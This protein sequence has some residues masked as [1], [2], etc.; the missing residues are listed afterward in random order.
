MES[1]SFLSVTSGADWRASRQPHDPDWLHQAADRLLY[2]TRAVALASSTERLMQAATEASVGIGGAESAGIYLLDDDRRSFTVGWEAT[3]PEWP[4]VQPAGVRLALGQWYGMVRAMEQG[5]AVPWVHGDS[6]LSQFEQEHYEREGVGSG[7]DVPLVRGGETVGFLKL[8]RRAR[9]T[10]SERD[11]TIAT[12]IAATIALAVVGERLLD[13]AR[14]QSHDQE[15]LARIAQVAIA[16]REPLDLL[17]RVADEIRVLLPFP[18]VD[19]ELWS[20]DLD[21]CEL[22]AHSAEPGWPAPTDGLVVYRLSERPANLRVLRELR[23]VTIDTRDELAAVERAYLTRRDLA[24]LHFVPLVYAEQC[25]GAIVIHARERVRFD[26]RLKTLIQ[27]AAAITALAARAARSLRETDWEGRA[28]SWQ[29]RVNNARLNGA[30]FPK[31]LDVALAALVDM[32]SPS[33]A[34]ITVEHTLLPDGGERRIAVSN[35]LFLS[36]VQ[37]W[38]CDTWPVALDARRTAQ[39]QLVRINDQSA[40]TSGA[41]C[42]LKRGQG[43]VLATPLLH[44][45]QTFGV[46]VLVFPTETS[47]GDDLRRFARLIARL[48]AMIASDRILRLETEYAARRA[49]AMLQ[50]TQAAIAGSDLDSL[51]QVIAGACLEMDQIDGCEIERYDPLARNL[52]NHTLVFGGKWRI[53]YLPGQTH[54]IDTWPMT[55]MVIESRTPRAFLT[56]SPELDPRESRFLR[57]I[58]VASHMIV[59]LSMGD[60]VLGVMTLYRGEAIPF[61]ARTVAFAGELAAQASLALGRARL[62]EALQARAETDGVT[63]LLN[64]RAI[65]ERIDEALHGADLR[66]EPLSLMLIDLDNFKLL[67]DVNGHLTG[68]RYLREM[69]ALIEEVVGAYGE[70]ARYGGDE[71]LVL[72]RRT[73]FDACNELATRLLEHGRQAGFDVGDYEVPFRFS[74]GTASAPTHGSTRE[75]LIRAADRAMYDAKDHGGGCLGSVDGPIDEVPPGTYTSLSGLVEAVDRKDHFTRVHSDRVTAIAVRFAIWLGRSDAEIEALYLAGQLHDVGKIAVPDSILRRPGRLSPEEQDRL[76]QHVLFSELMIK[77]VPQLDLVVG[78]VGAHHERW[79]GAGYPRGLAGEA[80]P[81][82]GRILSIADAVSAITQDRPYSRARSLDEALSE[83]SAHRGTQF[84]PELVD[85]FLRFAETG[86]L[87]DERPVPPPASL[88]ETSPAGQD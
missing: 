32:T 83:L 62:F 26:D 23:M 28:Q 88:T 86:A 52:V 61:S 68:D 69:A 67:N 17:Q 60:E 15:A 1:E 38:Q 25:I 81:E 20:P 11:V 6:F 80:I 3:V 74:I 22:L 58:G 75:Q 40:G 43:W 84:D 77:D 4:G 72:L 64:H 42:A 14:Q 35:N 2:V 29:L 55:R 87:A 39:Q 7:I 71:F 10:W 63:G 13:Q 27:E 19:I 53:P 66:H 73:G 44:D 48:T 24:Q 85:A 21:R 41:E 79:D 65:L 36:V 45:D 78:A 18:C 50:V 59:P 70:V 34:V 30:P 47:V 31:V 54:S 37:D 49:T 46:M 9:E 51:L 82:L 57:E 5:T 12:M 56:D 33:A 16:S 8:F 76:K